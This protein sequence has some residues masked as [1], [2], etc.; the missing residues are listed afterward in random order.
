MGGSFYSVDLPIL[1][2]LVSWG[3]HCKLFLDYHCLNNHLGNASCSQVVQ[4][5]VLITS[6]PKDV[7]SSE[8]E[9]KDNTS[10]VAFI[11]VILHEPYKL[12]TA[13]W[14]YHCIQDNTHKS[15]ERE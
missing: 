5:S 14:D 13:V 2:V 10:L 15:D 6:L 4:E 11:L 1:V 3:G 9:Y 7:S 12:S 8:N